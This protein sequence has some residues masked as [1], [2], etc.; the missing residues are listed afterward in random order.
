MNNRIAEQ[1]FVLETIYKKLFM[2]VCEADFTISL[3]AILEIF[4]STLTV[5]IE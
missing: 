4:F 2:S 5:N 1:K 3:I